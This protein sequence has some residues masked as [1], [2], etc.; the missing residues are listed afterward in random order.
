M[1][2][3]VFNMV[4]SQ[5]N[6]ISNNYNIN[7]N[8]S[9]ILQAPNSVIQTNFPVKIKDKYEI[10][11]G[12]RVQHNNICGPYKGGLRFNENVD[13]NEVSAL[14][15]WM[16]LKCSIQDLP[17]GGGKGGIAINP[18]NYTTEELERICR[19]FTQSMYK[20]IGASIDIPAPDVGTNSQMMNWM[21]DEYDKLSI[22]RNKTLNT[23]ATFT[24]K[25]IEVGG[26]QGREE[27]TG[28]GVAICVKEWANKKGI[29]LK[30][31]T[32][33]VQG[34]GNV[35]SFAAKKLESYGMKL[36]AV[37][38]HTGY[39]HHKDGFD[40]N[41]LNNYIKEHKSLKGYGLGETISDVK[42]FYALETDVCIPAALEMQIT[43]SVAKNLKCKMIVEAANGPVSEK[44][45]AICHEKNIDIIP[46]IL[47][48]SG[49][50]LVSY[51]EWLQNKQDYYW[52]EEKVL[53]KLEQNMTNAYGKIHDLAEKNNSNMRD[54][55]Y[56]YS[57]KRIETVYNKRG[58]H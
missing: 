20:H 1:S 3:K 43:E 51:F 28:T 38:D 26:S 36:I 47:A 22:A 7:K 50:V 24:G 18:E 46:D 58:I 54:A 41:D 5:I 55:C 32:Y 11:Q 33:I 42:D 15:T 31:K 6:K 44:A 21:T 34:F 57:L 9:A 19:G 49:G 37:G 2:L 29:D 16:T 52:S 45:D 30:G 12:Y 40:V 13:I 4:K 48:N 8:I 17:Y 35:G 10:F 27:A 56:Y 25:S 23:K 53:R 39:L 14:A